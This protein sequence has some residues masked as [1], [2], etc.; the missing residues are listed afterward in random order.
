MT[1]PEPYCLNCEKPFQEGDKFC[2]ACGQKKSKLALNLKDVLIQSFITVFNLDNTFLRSVSLLRTPWKVTENFVAGRKS[3]YYHP[4]RMF[5]VLL[6]L[7]FSCLSIFYDAFSNVNLGD[8]FFLTQNDFHK[9]DS[10]DAIFNKLG[11]SEKE[12]HQYYLSIFGEDKIPYDT[13]SFE[14]FIVI[15]VSEEKNEDIMIRDVLFLP[16]EEV[17][18]QYRVKGFLNRLFIKQFM[19]FYTKDGDLIS[20]FVKNMLWA[21]PLCILL[22][23]LAMLLLYFRRGFYLIEHLTLLFNLHSS[24]FFTCILVIVCE[25]AMPYDL[26]DWVWPCLGFAFLGLSILTLKLYYKQ[27]WIKTCIKFLILLILYSLF[28]AISFVLILIFSIALF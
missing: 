6:F 1:N 14:P 9:K 17:L 3:P 2:A 28:L 26:D 11:V 25:T 4:A 16:H 21:V 24:V 18:D 19:R 13:L 7:L 23:S 20:F 10:L 5:L 15:N 22:V 27:G 12:K 8:G